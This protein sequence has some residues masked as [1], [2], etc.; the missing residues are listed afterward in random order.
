MD[1]FLIILIG[2]VLEASPFIL[3]GAL[4][5]GIVEVFV[6]PSFVTRIMPRNPFLAIFIGTLLGICLPMCEC[7]SLIVV[8]RLIKKG[9]PPSAA[10]AYML[11]APIINPITVLSTYTAYSWFKEMVLW[12]AA[13]GA[14]T[15][16]LIG[17]IVQD[18]LKNNIMKQGK[19]FDLAILKEARPSFSEKIRHA[20]THAM[21]D[22]M[23]IFPMLLLGAT[24]T[25]CFKAFSPP[26]V[27]EF[28]DRG[29]WLSVPFL[30]GL[31]MVLSLCSQADAFVASA[32]SGFFDGPS[33][34]AFLVL[35]PMLDIK[36]IM[37]YRKVFNKKMLAVLYV[38]PPLVIVIICL[39][40][41]GVL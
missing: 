31:A 19:R 41:R 32:L 13:L 4:L 28:I 2:I 25:A 20:L 39:L 22:F 30:A 26:I 24:L 12:R 18:V 6:P 27:F 16:M 3:F 34:L 38:S 23:S 35:G 33:Q 11:S 21:D 1:D 9:A 10:I 17:I 29:A 14:G 40:L 7:G 36:L 15:A 37:M 8:K 5:S